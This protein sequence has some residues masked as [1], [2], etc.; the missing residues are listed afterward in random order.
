[1]AYTYFEKLSVF[2][3]V[4]PGSLFNLFIATNSCYCF[5]VVLWFYFDDIKT[6][7]HT[8]LQTYTKDG[9][10]MIFTYVLGKSDLLSSLILSYFAISLIIQNH[11]ALLSG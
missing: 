2:I 3:E 11:V 5:R 4:K 6:A 1:M 10:N 8:N 7:S 9:N